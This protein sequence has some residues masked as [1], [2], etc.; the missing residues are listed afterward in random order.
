LWIC[1]LRTGTSKK[2]ADLRFADLPTQNNWQIEAFNK[3]ILE[4]KRAKSFLNR[5]FEVCGEKSTIMFSNP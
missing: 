5:Q 1:D 3:G 4:K 2:F